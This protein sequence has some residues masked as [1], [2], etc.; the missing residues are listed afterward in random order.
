MKYLIELVADPK[1][2]EPAITAMDELNAKE[3]ELKAT[4]A[5][6]ST[7]QKK[8]L[9]AYAEKAKLGKASVDKLMDGYKQLSKAATGFVGKNVLNDASKAAIGLTKDLRLSTEQL[10]TMYSQGKLTEEQFLKGAQAIAQIKSQSN[11]A[12]QA[13]SVLSSDTFKFDAALQGVQLGAAGFQALQAGAALFGEESEDLQ[14]TL[15]KLNAIMAL[16]QSIQQIVNLTQ[17]QSAF[18]LGISVAAQKLYAIAVGQSTG[19]MKVFKIALASTGIGLL[20][21]GLGYLIANFDKLKTSSGFIGDSLRGLGKIISTVVDGF[22]TLTD[23]IGFTNFAMDEM[24]ERVTKNNDIILSKM[25]DGHRRKLALMKIQNKETLQTELDFARE[26]LKQLS[27]NNQWDDANTDIGKERIAK[28]KELTDRIEELKAEIQ[29]DYL[30]KRLKREK[31]AAEKAKKAAENA[32]NAQEIL[33][34]EYLDS[35]KRRRDLIAEREKKLT[36]QIQ[37]E[38]EI[39]LKQSRATNEKDLQEYKD[40][41]KRRRE[42]EAEHEKIRKEKRDI[43]EKEANARKANADK[44]QLKAAEDKELAIKDA[45]IQIAQQTADAI[46]QIANTNRNAEFNLQI[47]KLNELKD[48]ELANKELTDAQKER[49][50]LRYQKQVAAIKTKQAQ[51]DKQAAIVQAIINGALA[52]TKLYVSPGFPAAVP[53][54][55]VVAAT[56]AAQVAIIAAQKIPKFAKGTEFVKGGGTETSDSVPAMLSRGERVIDAKTNKLLK[57]IPNKMLP[58]LL[59]PDVSS[60]VN[61]SNFDYNKMA[62]VFSKELANN[63]ALMVNFDKSGFNTFI[64]NGVTVSQIKNNRNGV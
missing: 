52:I 13:I 9:D 44:V 20:V 48:K 22:K 54:A 29:Q 41:L 28:A 61:G 62:K 55:A 30:E 34:K 8:M 49:I 38:S 18:S 43:A 45:S 60:T 14:K 40:S 17:K 16:T 51:A 15:V 33:D 6:V 57:G 53:L 26:E 27:K 63:P 23:S 19:A 47:Q 21:I 50:E 2:L 58:Q 5:T 32:I 3:K 31:E 35:L 10:K 42:L 36:E 4:T 1:G 11:D 12:Q 46:F 25:E 37:K 39:R 64:K 24:A 7:E 59:I 56:T